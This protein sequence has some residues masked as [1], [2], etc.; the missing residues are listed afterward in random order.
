MFLNIEKIKCLI[1]EDD[2]FKME[3]ICSYLVGIFDSRI[4]IHK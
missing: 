3:G 1:V 4:E 2:Q